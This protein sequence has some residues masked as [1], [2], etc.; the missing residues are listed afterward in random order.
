MDQIYEHVFW[1][2]LKVI[3]T[4]HIWWQV[5]IFSGNGLVLVQ[6]QAIIWTSVDPD[7]YCHMAS[8][9]HNELIR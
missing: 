4:E 2:C 7:L 8:L 3:S 5:N 1:N 9:G 6:Q